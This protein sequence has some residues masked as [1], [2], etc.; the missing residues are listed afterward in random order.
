MDTED[1]NNKQKKMTVKYQRQIIGV[2]KKL[3]FLYVPSAG[4]KYMPTI[5][6]KFS[7]E[8]EGEKGG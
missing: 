7:V 2:E 6:G 3:G 4:Q 8:L 5:N 1:K